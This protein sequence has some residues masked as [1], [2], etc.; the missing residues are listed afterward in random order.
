MVGFCSCFRSS[1]TKYDNPVAVTGDHAACHV[2]QMPQHAP[3]SPYQL[4][5]PGV[6]ERLTSLQDAMQGASGA[7][8]PSLHP[9]C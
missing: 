3:V 5:P 4:I 9:S 6:V 2:V 7:K 1:S 8:E